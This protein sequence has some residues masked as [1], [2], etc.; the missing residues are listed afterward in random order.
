MPSSLKKLGPKEEKIRE[1]KKK[2]RVFLKRMSA[3]R[4]IF[5][6]LLIIVIFLPFFGTVND[7]L[8]KIIEH[9]RLFVYIQDYIVPFLSRV[10]AVILS[11]F[12]FQAVGVKEGLYIPEKALTVNIAWNCVG[13]Q[14]LIL[15]IITLISGLQGSYT[16]LSK[17]QAVLI[18]LLGTFL[19]NVIRISSV[20]LFAVW[21]G[22]SA[23]VIYHDYFSSLLII[24]W[25]LFFW[26]F[27]YVYVL[28]FRSIR[29]KAA[30]KGKNRWL[31]FLK[32]LLFKAKKFMRIGEKSS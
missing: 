23:T 9:T 5:L 12:G 25:L 16:K 22:H 3:F 4:L 19:I 30:Q 27:C 6:A 32:K 11:P 21:F 18:G 7:I 17:F 26:W 13:W 31:N 8:T 10:V 1:K 29:D 20:V 15:I 24:F 14:S 2:A 28:E